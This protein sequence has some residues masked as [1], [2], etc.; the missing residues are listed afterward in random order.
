M[1]EN[2]DRTLGAKMGEDACMCPAVDGPNTAC[3]I[4]LR[5]G[6][7]MRRRE[8]AQNGLDQQRS[9]HDAEVAAAALAKSRRRATSALF[10]RLHAER[11]ACADP[12]FHHRCVFGVRHEEFD[13]AVLNSLAWL[14]RGQAV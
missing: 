10:L 11:I 7:A 9:R 3:K 14:F 6:L 8:H 5:T 2:R 13:Q 12:C 4:Q 1:R